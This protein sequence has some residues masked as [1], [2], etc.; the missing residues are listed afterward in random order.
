MSVP[1]PAEAE[2]VTEPLDPRPFDRAGPAGRTRR[3]LTAILP[4]VLFALVLL[5]MWSW[6][7]RG[8]PAT[9]LPRPGA[10]AATTW[11][12]A[13]S[14][15]LFEIA[16][17]SMRMMAVG[18]A[19]S[20]IVGVGAGLLIA[21]RR[22]ADRAISPYLIGLQ[23]LP[24]AAWVPFAFIAFGAAT[25]AVLAVTIVGALPSIAIGT[26]DSVHGVPPLL[27][28]AA[29]TLGARRGR[30]MV[31]V[32]V[33]ASL[34]GIVTGLE[35]GWAFAFRSLVAGELIAGSGHFGFGRFIKEAEKAKQVDRM[36]AGV[37][38]IMLIGVVVDRVVFAQAR[39]RLGDRRGLTAGAN[40]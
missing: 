21:T 25:P 27:L 14:G 17:T 9:E 4:P 31:R 12:L 5:A 10:V 32:V 38:C 6:L 15:E 11:D 16:W 22:T 3:I 35:Q 26:R 37:L 19:A 34:P 20:A 2:A 1:A 23:S 29:R 13:A 30:L 7:A 18:F 36:L 33:P 8:R 24:A 40:G 39:R 28:R